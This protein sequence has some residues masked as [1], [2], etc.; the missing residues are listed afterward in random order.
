MDLIHRLLHRTSNHPYYVTRSHCQRCCSGL[1]HNSTN[2]LANRTGRRAVNCGRD[3]VDR[4]LSY[5]LR[6]DHSGLSRDLSCDSGRDWHHSALYC[7]GNSSST[8]T[9]GSAPCCHGERD[10]E[11]HGFLLESELLSVRPNRT[12]NDRTGNEQIRHIPRSV[13]SMLNSVADVAGDRCK[14]MPGVARGVEEIVCSA[15][16]RTRNVRQSTQQSATDD[17]KRRV[18]GCLR[19][20]ASDAAREPREHASGRRRS[21][22]RRIRRRVRRRSGRA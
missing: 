17:R 1:S 14:P 22:R 9:Q 18:S 4:L 16:D 11:K 5:N 3:L 6:S 21:I 8:E 19:N 12:A 2:S 20:C 13:C 10:G 7:R 15:A